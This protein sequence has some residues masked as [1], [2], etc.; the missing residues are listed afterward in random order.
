MLLM[1]FVQ[2]WT[3]RLHQNGDKAGVYAAPCY[4]N[5]NMTDWW[6]LNSPRPDDVWIAHWL[7]PQDY[8]PDATVWTSCLPDTYWPDYQRLRQYAGDHKET[9]GGVLIDIDSDVMRGEITAVTGTVTTTAI[10]GEQLAKI[11]EVELISPQVGWVLQGDQILLTRD[12]GER[13]DDITP[14]GIVG[15]VH[16]VAFLDASKGWVARSPNQLSF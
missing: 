11:R 12:G 15:S 8:N 1:S 6:N 9:W 2:G 7:L 10:G 16:D 5:S 4:S 3:D 14:V 13:W